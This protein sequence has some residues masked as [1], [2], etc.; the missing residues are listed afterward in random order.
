MLAIIIAGALAASPGAPAAV[1]DAAAAPKKDKVVC[2]SFPKTE[3][4]V[5][6]H[7]ICRPRSEWESVQREQE[8]EF[9]QLKVDN[10]IMLKSDG[11]R[12]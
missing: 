2:K 1:A 5:G 4:R 6:R 12:S 11:P 10:T 3:S 7:R 8:R 9:D